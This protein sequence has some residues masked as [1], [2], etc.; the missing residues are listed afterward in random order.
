MCMHTQGQKQK[1][2]RKHTSQRDTEGDRGTEDSVMSTLR[3][4]PEIRILLLLKLYG[5]A[6][7]ACVKKKADGSG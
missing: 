3:M 6:G 5:G 4:A 2:E 1:G 7:R